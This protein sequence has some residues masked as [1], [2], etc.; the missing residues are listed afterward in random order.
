[1]R[2]L[3]Q[4]LLLAL[5]VLEDLSLSREIPWNRRDASSST[6]RRMACTTHSY[7]VSTQFER[8]CLAAAEITRKRHL[9]L[10]EVFLSADEGRGQLDDGVSPVVSPA[11]P[12]QHVNPDRKAVTLLGDGLA[13]A[14]VEQSFGEEAAQELLA[15]VAVERFSRFPVFDHLNPPKESSASDV[16]DNWN[17]VQFLKRFLKWNLTRA[18][19]TP[20]TE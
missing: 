2:R 15:L 8:G 7:Y 4:S 20:S 1:M 12:A 17:V 13:Q 5:M 18:L 11:V 10:V 3:A 6:R 14:V 9:D 19:P 16:A